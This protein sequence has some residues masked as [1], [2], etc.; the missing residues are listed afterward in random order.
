[1]TLKSELGGGHSKSLKNSAI[2]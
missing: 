1:M 2:R